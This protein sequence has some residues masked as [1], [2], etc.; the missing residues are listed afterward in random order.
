MPTVS[1][2]P[3]AKRQTEFRIPSRSFAITAEDAAHML[4]SA[5]EDKQAAK[6]IKA[7]K[8]LHKAASKIISEQILVR[9]KAQ[10]K[11]A[12]AAAKGGKA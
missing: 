8:V 1:A 9:R 2:V 7:N 6:E 4:V 11:T 5:E 3:Q 10:V 12:E